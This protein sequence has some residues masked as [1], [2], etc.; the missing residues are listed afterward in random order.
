MTAR[1]Y[2]AQKAAGEW[3][4]RAEQVAQANVEPHGKQRGDRMRWVS[5]S[6]RISQRAG[7]FTLPIRDPLIISLPTTCS[8][9]LPSPVRQ[10]MAPGIDQLR[11]ASLSS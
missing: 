11:L 4:Q 1:Q 6:V 5:A 8:W 3:H 2:V 10:E 9:S 7:S